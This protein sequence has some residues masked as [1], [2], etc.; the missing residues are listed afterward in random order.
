MEV[1]RSACVMLQDREV[2]PAPRSISNLF[3]LKAQLIESLKCTPFSSS[4]CQNG[5]KCHRFS[6]TMSTQYRKLIAVVIL[7]DVS[8]ILKILANISRAP[9]VTRP[10]SSH[11][12]LNYQVFLSKVQK[13][14]NG[15]KVRLRWSKQRRRRNCMHMAH[16]IFTLS[17]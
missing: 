13:V 5:T 3:S 15:T 14:A 12:A 4:S 8:L 2:R 16:P 6:Q 9:E 17:I 10:G 11:R 1:G 7:G